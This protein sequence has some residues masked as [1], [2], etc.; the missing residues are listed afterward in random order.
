MSLRSWSWSYGERQGL[1]GRGAGT[2]RTRDRRPLRRV[3]AS[4]EL[5][6]R[7][8]GRVAEEGQA[9]DWSGS[10]EEAAREP[11]R[12][13]VVHGH[14]AVAFAED[15]E[16]RPVDAEGAVQVVDDGLH[17]GPVVVARVPVTSAAF[18]ERGARVVAAGVGRADD[19]RAVVA[20]RATCDRSIAHAEGETPRARNSIPYPGRRRPCRP[21]TR[22]SIRRA[23][24][25]R[26]YCALAERRTR[27]RYERGRHGRDSDRWGVPL[28]VQPDDERRAAALRAR[29]GRVDDV[30]AVELAL[31]VHDD[32]PI[33][34]LVG[35]SRD[36]EA[37]HR[38]PNHQ[39]QESSHALGGLPLRQLD[40]RVQFKTT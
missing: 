9:E 34:R 11:R 37:K 21:G 28:A 1:R 24:R 18:A 19:A 23:R 13:Q 4:Q 2:P 8:A 14:A 16:P 40:S 5:H 7:R 22:R 30:R 6:L 29:G 35:C 25:S 20:G 26:S 38:L 3:R 17:E 12:D 31:V 33:R 27:C 10:E 36:R 32:G 15:E 39:P